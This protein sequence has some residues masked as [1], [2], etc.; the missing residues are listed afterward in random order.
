ITTPSLIPVY[1]QM[2][3]RN[4]RVQKFNGSS[5]AVYLSRYEAY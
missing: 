2:L 5:A 1:V 4:A 3:K